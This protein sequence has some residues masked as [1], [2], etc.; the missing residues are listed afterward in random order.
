VIPA[1]GVSAETVAASINVS[2]PG[3]EALTRSEAVASAPGVASVQSSFAIVLALAIAV[4]A[5]VTGFFFLI[6]TVQKTASLTL[7][8]AVGAPAGYLIRGLLQQVALVLGAALVFAVLLL[9]AAVAGLSAG[10][11]L[12]IEPGALLA[13]TLIILVLS[14]LGVAFSIWR[15]LRIEPVHAVTRPLM[16][17]AE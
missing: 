14:M 9:Q 2:V 17:G 8:R 5:L 4:V 13:S 16:G 12:T 15:V 10:L 1:E 6:L 7:L 11:P 3:V